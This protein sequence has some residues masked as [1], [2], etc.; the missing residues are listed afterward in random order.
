LDNN[1]GASKKVLLC[2]LNAFNNRMKLRTRH[3]SFITII[4]ISFIGFV[5]CVMEDEKEL[6]TF[7]PSSVQYDLPKILQDGKLTVL[8][9]N[10]STSFFI[11]RG[12]KMGFEYEVLKE[13]ANEIGVV[14]TIK[15]IDNL[16]D[17]TSMLN[18]GQGDLIACNYTI[19]KDRKKIIDFSHPFIRSN[20]V[21]IQRKPDNWKQ[22]SS[23]A[24]KASLAVQEPSQL[25]H[26]HVSVWK[27]SS[28]YQRLKNLQEEIGDT[29]FINGVQGK[30]GSEELIEMVAEGMI[31]FTVAEDNIA[32]VNE[33]FFNNLDISVPIS[34]KQRIAFGIRKSSPLLKARLDEWLDDFM[35][36]PTFKYLRHKYFNVASVTL[37]SQDKYSSLKGQIS[38]YDTY[39]K[40]AAAK[41]NWDWRLLAALSYQ[42]SH[43][44]PL[45][46]S[47][48]GA[49]SMMQF[50]P[51]VGPI[52]GVHPDSP[53]KKQI[54]GGMKK[55]SVDYKRWNDI[56]DYIQ[57]WKFAIASYN[58]GTGHIRDAQ[59]LASKKGLNP[60]LWDD[61]VEKMV[62]NLSK[63]EYYHDVDVRYGYMRGSITYKYVRSIFARYY[64]WKD[65]YQ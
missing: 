46:V 35:K 23:K 6:R 14:L 53:P 52:Y 65:L 36:K 51:E 8:A 24:I 5:G 18:K 37:K 32:R 25:A 39:F 2:I 42:E 28:Y 11:Y 19:T 64:E 33:R 13:F 41:Y 47:F 17:I 57:R 4:L 26:K 16:D 61:N 27:E 54:M 56:P 7:K 31:D 21:L 34:V 45:A 29:I 22:L 15:T 9:E 58:A 3:T 48:G 50:M 10:S 40:E 49:Y 63:Q 38:V 43:F 60:L 12:R 30:I 62:L 20:Q 55:L 1:Y 59:R 44:N